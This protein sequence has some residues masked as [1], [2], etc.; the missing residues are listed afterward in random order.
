M[1]W[2]HIACHHKE[3]ISNLRCVLEILLYI[4]ESYFVRR[5]KLVNFL[6][7]LKFFFL[8]LIFFFLKRSSCF[9]FVNN[10]YILVCCLCLIIFCFFLN[11]SVYITH[12]IL[13]C[14]SYVFYFF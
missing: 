3:R 9:L 6:G 5:R 13:C 1:L 8:L 4:N 14:F 11:V 12:E 10:S 7:R 2:L